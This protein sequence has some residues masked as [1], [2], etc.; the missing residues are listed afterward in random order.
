LGITE[1]VPEDR[2]EANLRVILDEVNRH[3]SL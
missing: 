2:W 1:D 3:P